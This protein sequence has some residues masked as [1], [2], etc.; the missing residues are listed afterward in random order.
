MSPASLYTSHRLLTCALTKRLPRI[1]I[2]V[3]IQAKMPVSVGPQSCSAGTTLLVHQIAQ[4][5]VPRQVGLIAAHPQNGHDARCI[6]LRSND[7]WEQDSN[8]DLLHQ[9]WIS[10]PRITAIRAWSSLV[11]VSSTAVAAGDGLLCPAFKVG[12]FPTVSSRSLPQDLI[13]PF[14]LDSVVDTRGRPG[15]SH[16]ARSA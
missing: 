1:M 2:Y 6:L 10:E 5:N 9:N 3:N 4:D 15:S 8:R 13:N 11:R 7:N 16:V 14:N 12:Q